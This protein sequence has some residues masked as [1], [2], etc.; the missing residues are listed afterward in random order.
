MPNAPKRFN[1]AYWDFWEEKLAN[2][3]EGRK[4]REEIKKKNEKP[5]PVR[6]P[7][8][9]STLKEQLKPRKK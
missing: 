4:L 2:T 8:T 1:L 5:W 7:D 9:S 6:K 3:P